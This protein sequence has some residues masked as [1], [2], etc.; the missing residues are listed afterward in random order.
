MT[1]GIVLSSVKSVY[2]FP[3]GEIALGSLGR[4]RQIWNLTA[5]SL[6]KKAEKAKR[7]P[8][9]LT[10]SFMRK[11]APRTSTPEAEARMSFPI[12]E[13][14][15]PRMPVGGKEVRNIIACVCDGVGKSAWENKLIVECCMMISLNGTLLG[16]IVVHFC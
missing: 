12:L 13:I 7:M 11:V 5:L 6:L 9:S 15:A 4:G 8:S 16:F 1:E 10:M 3:S 14:R 2:G